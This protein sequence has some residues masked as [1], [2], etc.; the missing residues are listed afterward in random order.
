MAVLW[1]VSKDLGRTASMVERAVGAFKRYQSRLGAPTWTLNETL[2][3]DPIDF[4]ILQG[5]IVTLPS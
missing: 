1:W 4:F 2:T 3:R 5:P